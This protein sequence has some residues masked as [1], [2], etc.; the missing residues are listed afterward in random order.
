MAAEAFRLS[1][2]DAYSLEGGLTAWSEQGKEL[3]TG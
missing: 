2:Y 3:E 1:G